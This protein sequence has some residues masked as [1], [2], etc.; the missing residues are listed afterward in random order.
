MSLEGLGLR[1]KGRAEGFGFEW[2]GVEGLGLRV[3]V[4]GLRVWG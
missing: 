1:V 4:E 3:G 2:F